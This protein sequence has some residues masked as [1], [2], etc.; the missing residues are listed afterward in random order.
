MQELRRRLRT[1][2]EA[3]I[4]RPER[5]E[6]HR[7]F[8]QAADDLACAYEEACRRY[9]RCRTDPA[10]FASMYGRELITWVEEGP[11][12]ALFS[13][14]MNVYPYTARAYR[15]MRRA[16]LGAPEGGTEH[17]GGASNGM[18]IPREGSRVRTKNAWKKQ[19]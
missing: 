4:E 13:R 18:S 19:V 8:D 7:A 1:L 6:E 16:L 11:R 9:Y 10:W 17:G 5:E 3:L 2:R 15:E 14:R 12:R